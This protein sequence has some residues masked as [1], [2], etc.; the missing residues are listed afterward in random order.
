MYTGMLTSMISGLSTRLVASSDDEKEPDSRSRR[1]H[2]LPLLS[3]IWPAMELVRPR[4]QLRKYFK[5]LK[6]LHLNS[7]KYLVCGGAIITFNVQT[8]TITLSRLSK[9]TAPRLLPPVC[10]NI[11]ISD[12]EVLMRACCLIRVEAPLY[13]CPECCFAVYWCG[14][15]TSIIYALGNFPQTP[16]NVP[17][18]ESHAHRVNLRASSN[19]S[20]NDAKCASLQYLW[21]KR[22]SL[23]SLRPQSS[24]LRESVT[25]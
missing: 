22:R 6:Q 17:L 7:G 12:P 18:F 9:L 8:L 13:L 2:N 3:I 4:V 5:A 24:E 25:L 21:F 10:M 1:I 15:T 11:G 19:S 16:A 14:T 20:R 23:P